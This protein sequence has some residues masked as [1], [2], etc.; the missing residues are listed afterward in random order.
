MS[1]LS[2]PFLQAPLQGVS[3]AVTG[4]WK[5]EFIS[6]G[7]SGVSSLIESGWVIWL[8]CQ[9]WV[10]E[11]KK[12]NLQ[13]VQSN[14]LHYM[15][16]TPGLKLPGMENL[17]R[18]RCCLS[19]LALTAWHLP[20]SSRQNWKRSC[21][22]ASSSAEE[23]NN[24]SQS[25]VLTAHFPFFLFFR[26]WKLLEFRICPSFYSRRYDFQE[27]GGGISCLPGCCCCSYLVSICWPAR[28]YLKHPV[29]ILW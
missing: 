28:P 9:G 7:D 21:W 3:L 15:H 19:P 17:L 5:V 23:V 4:L 10:L 1:H 18:L 20:C 16:Y 27:S 29:Y 12:W 2:L 8:R 25:E 24:F 14:Q 26:E 11:M 6:S 13:K 22:V